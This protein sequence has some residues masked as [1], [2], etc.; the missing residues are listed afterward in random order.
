MATRFAL[1]GAAS[2][3]TP[4]TRRG[5]WNVASGEDLQL[6]G[7]KPQGAVGTSTINVGSTAANRTVLLHRSISAGAIKA[8]TISGT[9]S[10]VIGVKESATALNG[11][12][13]LHV[14]V[15]S[16]DSDTPRGTLLSNFTGA[17]TFTT[18]ATGAT[19][20][21][22]A[23]TPVAVQVGDRIVAEIGYSASAGATTQNATINY[24]QI[25]TT[26]LAAGA[27]SVTT[28]PSWIEL[29]GTDGLFTP[30]FSTL[31]DGFTSIGAA[32]TKTA[33][34]TA[35]GGRA[36]IPCTATLNSLTTATAYEI[37]GS[38]IAF[39]I[40]TV[41][42]GGT[43]AVFSAYIGPG[44][45]LTNTNLEFEYS[46]ATGNLVLRNNV[47]GVDATPT[48]LT[49][50]A[51]THQW[52]RI[53]ESGGSIT[54]DTSP[55]GSTW[56]TRRTISTPSQWMRTGTLIAQ[57]E[58]Q[59]TSGTSTNAEVDNVNTGP[60]TI[61]IAAGT[62]VETST[63]RPTTGQRISPPGRGTEADAARPAAGQKAFQAGHATEADT[64]KAAA[65]LRTVATGRA[66]E[67]DAVIA[68]HPLR[69]AAAGRALEADTARP[70]A[71]QRSAAAGT[72]TEADMARS[73]SGTR[74]CTAGTTAET[75]T[76]I[77]APG[78]RQALAGH[79][80]ETSTARPATGQRLA[81]A[82]T[83]LETDTAIAPST[84]NGPLLGTVRAG[85]PLTRRWT[86]A[87]A[88][89]RWAARS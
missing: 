59:N 58:A 13:R 73:A 49:Y 50:N 2:P 32:W 41:P 23:V 24:G 38:E 78:A 20:G 45:T 21:A 7:R 52:W 70:A 10:W 12:W 82:G 42:T 57:F 62:A 29:S 87:P 85:A 71:G 54:M 9:I 67:S 66:L 47:A 60:G 37:Q 5:T 84:P 11:V 1:T 89:T 80:T 68:A 22:Q 88:R 56:T 46:V 15:T 77:A 33:A 83:A 63:A 55:D 79:P 74:T 53:R 75:D 3:Y 8:G 76:A 30:A 6:L 51:T 34:V 39:Q 43:G 19:E 16:G 18:T 28:D 26:D 14:Y 81:A 48:T 64:A 69:T 61:I 40:P 17:T 36:V 86:A 27:T 65:G 25:G 35:S 31:V 72:T 4:T 44:P